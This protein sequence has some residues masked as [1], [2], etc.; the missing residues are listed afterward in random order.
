MPLDPYHLTPSAGINRVKLISVPNLPEEW[1]GKSAYQVMGREAL[2]HR[3]ITC[4]PELAA[5]TD[6]I[7]AFCEHYLIDNNPEAESIAD[8]MGR[9]LGY[10]LLT[11]KTGERANG[12]TRPEWDDTYWAHWAGIQ[13]IILGGGLMA[14]RMGTHMFRKASEMLQGLISLRIAPYPTLL[15][16]IGISRIAEALYV[17]DFG[18]TN[19]KRA[20]PVYEDE[21]LVR[22]DQ[23]P[24]IQVP[25]FDEVRDLFSFMV[26]TI[27]NTIPKTQAND[28]PVTILI[29]LA[30]YVNGC[31]LAPDHP[32][33]RLNTLGEDTC[34]LL[35][36]AVCEQI[37]QTVHIVLAHDGTSAAKVFAGEKNT[38]VIT[39]GTALGIGFPPPATDLRKISSQFEVRYI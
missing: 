2:V 39:V 35:S 15:P 5:L 27:A 6:P 38:G 23:L 8:E 26:K 24:S 25:K 14:S 13:R 9:A 36:E 21:V 4:F 22:L 31:Q 20:H 18:G 1:K 32:Y 16:L 33:G 10:L 30:N 11:I 28:Q 37:G 7:P 34:Q 12:E 19:V 3:V 17:F 29:S